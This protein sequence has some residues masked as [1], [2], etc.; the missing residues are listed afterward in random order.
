MV[1]YSCAFSL[2]ENVF[3]GAIF[4]SMTIIVLFCFLFVNKTNP[5]P[6]FHHQA[7]YDMGKILNRFLTESFRKSMLCL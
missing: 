2:R 1:K 6:S 5:T 3:Y 7:I 4:L